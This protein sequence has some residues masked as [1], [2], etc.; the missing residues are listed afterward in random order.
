MRNF[1]S[2]MLGLLFLVTYSGCGGVGQK[3]ISGQAKVIMETESVRYELY[4]HQHEKCLKE[5]K[6]LEGYKG[7]MS[8]ARH[9]ARAADSYAE[10]LSGAQYAYRIKGANGLKEVMPCLIEAANKLVDALKAANVPV[11]KEVEEIA[12]YVSEVGGECK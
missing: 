2:L 5:S 3:I 12:A 4:G 8:V 6:D 11:P 10:A 1:A 7:C 9:V